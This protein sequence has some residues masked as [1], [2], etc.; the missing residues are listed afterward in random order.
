MVGLVR[1]KELHP[2]TATMFMCPQVTNLQGQVV[3]LSKLL[4]FLKI[5]NCPLRVLDILLVS[6]LD[7]QY[8]GCLL[9][10]FP[11]VLKCVVVPRVLYTCLCS[12]PAVLHINISHKGMNDTNM[13]VLS[14][15]KV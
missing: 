9:P 1:W 4:H 3:K 8:L 7:T 6:P 14:D 5:C 13:S 12:A 11:V 15:E 2:K 10:C